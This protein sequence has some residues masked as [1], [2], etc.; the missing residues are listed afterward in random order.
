MLKKNKKA[1]TFA[2]GM[3]FVAAT[4]TASVALP[5]PQQLEVAVLRDVEGTLQIERIP[6]KDRKEGESL[7]RKISDD[8]GVVA[9]SIPGKIGSLEG[10]DPKRAEQW[11]LDRLDADL[12]SP[13]ATG[14]GVTVAVVDTGVDGSHPD[15][16]GVI[17][18]GYDVIGN[19][20]GRVDP[21]GHGTHI[22]GIIAARP[23]NGIGVAGLAPGVKILPVRALDE[24]GYGD[25]AGIAE[26][27]IWAADNGADII[28]LSLGSDVKDPV[29]AAAV[30]AV[31]DRGVTVIAASG[32]GGIQGSPVSYPGALPG[33]LAVSASSHG[34]QKAMFSTSGDYVGISAP[35][36]SIMS[37]WTGGDYAYSSGTSMATPFVVASAALVQQK[38]DLTGPELI[39]RLTSSATDA[40]VPGRDIAFGFGI[41]DPYAALTDGAPRPPRGGSG[42]PGFPTMPDF[43]AMPG[44]PEMGMPEMPELPKRPLPPLDSPVRG[45]LPALP[46]LEKPDLKFDGALTLVSSSRSGESVSIKAKLS[47]EGISLGKRDIKASIGGA[48]VASVAT[49]P[50]GDATI[51]V[52]AP[53]GTVITVSFAGDKVARAASLDVNAP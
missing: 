47:V 51:T 3:S 25:D 4:L 14:E 53:V 44:L 18:S 8:P 12:V 43:P 29:L 11:G 38:M 35:G 7:I 36:V 23:N 21:N 16:E 26:G 19:S 24:T 30:D 52:N 17:L 37:T 2:V 10:A 28:N 31:I 40:G 1:L 49:D 46:P 50:F 20:D 6:V 9:A 34:D 27:V 48:E 15:L 33:V 13:L 45:E 41:V 42:M 5:D 32:N 39:N 22:A